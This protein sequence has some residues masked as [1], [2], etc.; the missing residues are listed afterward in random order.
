M[1]SQVIALLGLGLIGGSL[2]LAFKSQNLQS[3]KVIG[4]DRSAQSMERAVECGA[5]DR[6]ISGWEELKEADIVFLCTPMQSILPLAQTIRPYL[7]AGAILTDV[8]SVKEC[9]CT[10]LAEGGDAFC[11]IGG[12]PMAGKEKSGIEAADGTLFQGKRYILT[13]PS[14]TKPEVLAALQAVIKVTG[15]KISFMMPERHDVCAAVISHLPHVAAAGLVNTLGYYGQSEEILQLAGGGFRDTTRIASSNA[16]MWTDI[17]LTNKEKIIASLKKYQ[18]VLD[19]LMQDIEQED[20]QAIEAYFRMAKSRRDS[21]LDSYD[22]V[23]VI[24]ETPD[25]NSD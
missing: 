17:C 3:L 6:F 20:Q 18:L 5:I 9:L 1:K 10:A 8:G 16:T 15:A 4:W 2:G 7:K 21:L 24:S 14:G 22:Q 25:S 19:Q 12:H 11:Y 13:P 23:A